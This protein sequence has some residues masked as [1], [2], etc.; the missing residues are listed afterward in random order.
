M[1]ESTVLTCHFHNMMT[2]EPQQVHNMSN[3]T[4]TEPQQL[5][6]LTEVQEVQH[7]N[8]NLTTETQ[9]TQHLNNV[10]PIYSSYNYIIIITIT[11]CLFG[12]PGNLVIMKIMTGKGFNKMAHSIICVALA[13]INSAYLL[14]MLSINILEIYFGPYFLNITLCSF[15][16]AVVYFCIHVDA[17]FLT[18][19][20]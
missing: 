5:N 13:I 10:N 15:N 19:L 12:I 14:Y 17:A 7:L 1:N 8:I 9:E 16:Y 20:T 11:V 4:T 2:T 3:M 18:F 6:L